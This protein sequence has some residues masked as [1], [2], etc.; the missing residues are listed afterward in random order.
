MNIFL[1]H[2]R[3]FSDQPENLDN[4]RTLCSEEFI[5]TTT[6]EEEDCPTELLQ[7][8]NVE[9]VYDQVH[10]SSGGFFSSF[11][12]RVDGVYD[13]QREV[14]MDGQ[15]VPISI[16]GVSPSFQGVTYHRED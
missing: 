14:W 15:G 3:V 4:A 11:D 16:P 13:D 9:A 7:V 6:E 2:S 12:F 1:S 8:E 10:F 5:P